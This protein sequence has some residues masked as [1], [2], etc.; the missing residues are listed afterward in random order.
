MDNKWFFVNTPFECQISTNNPPTWYW[1]VANYYEIDVYKWSVGLGKYTFCWGLPKL[2]KD[3][4]VTPCGD[5]V[6]KNQDNWKNA[7]RLWNLGL[8]GK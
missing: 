7:K 5:Y 8:R 2:G 3:Y 1:P 6:W 4:V